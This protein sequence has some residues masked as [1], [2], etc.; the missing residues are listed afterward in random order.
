MGSRD[1]IL[2]LYRRIWAHSD[3]TIAASPLD[4][5]GQVPWWPRIVPR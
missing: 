4:A 3:E 2:G 1:Q 5:I